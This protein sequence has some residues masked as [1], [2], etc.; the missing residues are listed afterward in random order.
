MVAADRT[1]VCCGVSLNVSARVV[2]PRLVL[3]IGRPDTGL[4]PECSL[5]RGSSAATSTEWATQTG[6]ARPGWVKAWSAGAGSPA[7]PGL[8][9]N[10]S[11]SAA[12]AAPSAA[13]PLVVHAEDLSVAP[14]ALRRGLGRLGLLC[15]H[16][17]VESRV[18]A[19]DAGGRQA[20]HSQRGVGDAS[21]SRRCVWQRSAS[22]RRPSSRM[23]R[24]RRCGRTE[25]CRSGARRG[26]PRSRPRRTHG[27][28]PRWES[29][30]HDYDRRRRATA[31]P[32]RPG[33][34]G[35][36]RIPTSC[37][38]TV[39]TS[40]VCCPVATVPTMGGRTQRPDP[41]HKKAPQCGAFP[42][43]RSGQGLNP[44]AR[45]ETIVRL[46]LDPVNRSLRRRAR[47]T[48]TQPR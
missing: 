14:L 19:L 39:G 27:Q 20:L 37:C 24:P 34:R 2:R 8:I 48:L 29:V 16:G 17:L 3:C 22:G 21:A 33:A 45:L 31:P 15:A 26:R 38:Q 1:R 42:V 28:R 41:R 46:L 44:Q 36:S 32:S 30:S 11:S 4:R 23:S 47:M 35:P 25:P 43:R 5:R 10:A 13:G 6:S 9:R 12:S 40:V 7:V 18:L